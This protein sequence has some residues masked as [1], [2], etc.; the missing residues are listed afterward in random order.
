MTSVNIL[1]IVIAAIASFAIGSV[2]YSPVAFGRQWMALMGIDEKKASE[3]GVSGMWKLYAAQFITTLVMFLV[4]GF[5][6]IATGNHGAWNGATLGGIV[7]FGFAATDAVGKVLWEKKPL[8]LILINLGG[9]LVAL[10]VGGAIIG[11]MS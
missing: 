6:F 5:L 10:I 3:A 7:W 9:S 8:K 2:W 4:L 1:S 11:A